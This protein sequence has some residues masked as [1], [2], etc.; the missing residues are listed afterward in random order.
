MF[1]DPLHVKDK[2]VAN[3]AK[4]VKRPYHGAFLTTCR[5]H[6]FLTQCT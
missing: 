3:K 4:K 2:L 1:A 5:V 6:I